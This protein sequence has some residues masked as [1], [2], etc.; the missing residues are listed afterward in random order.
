VHITVEQAYDK[1][2]AHYYGTRY[3]TIPYFKDFWPNNQPTTVTISSS[4]NT[5]LVLGY[6]KKD[7]F[8]IDGSIS[9]GYSKSIT[10]TNPHVNAQMS[11]NLLTA[12]WSY[13]YDKNRPWTHD[14]ESN[15][16]YEISSSGGNMLYGDVRLKLD[17]KFVV[18]RAGFYSQQPNEESLDLMVRIQNSRIYDFCN[19]MI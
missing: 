3:G 18:D 19:G 12:Q 14:Q 1:N 5:G 10:Y 7:G 8:G 6:S 17:Y 2:E 4:L 9:Y 11:P 13:K 16:M 15:Y